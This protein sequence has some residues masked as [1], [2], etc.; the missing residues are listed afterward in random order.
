MTH[1][2]TITNTT[3]FTHT[4]AVH[5][6]AKVATDLKRMHRFYNQPSDEWI[7]NFEIEVVELLKG[8]YLGTVT[9]GFQRNGRWIEPTLSYTAREL[10]GATAS[11]NDPGR[12]R[13][14]AS[15]DGA[16]FHSYLTYSSAWSQSSQAQ[17]QEVTKRIPFQ[18]SAGPEP[19]VAGY[20][21]NDLTYSAG[22]RA[23][24]RASLRS[25]Q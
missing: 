14:G 25:N 5:I 3:T 20:W 2:Y 19:G 16:S 9:Y 18:R 21:S 11:D 24:D 4:H 6:A 1:S 22:N 23:L 13:P 15:T 12:V 8:G 10:S 17:R 7:R